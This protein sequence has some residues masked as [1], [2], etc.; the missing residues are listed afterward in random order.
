MTLL[1]KNVQV[2]GARKQLP[3][4]AD[5][6]INGDTIS[7][8]GSFPGK[9]A[10]TVIDG[11]ACYLSSGF[12]DA[13][14]ASDHYLSLF[15]DPGQE[16]FLLQG[17]TTIIGGQ[18]GA[19]LAP[20]LYGNLDSIR[21]W[22]NPDRVNVNWH[23]MREF[24]EHFD[25]QPRGVNFATLAGHGTVR[26]ALIGETSRDL[27]KNELDV[28]EKVMREALKDGACGIST[29]LEYVHTKSTPYREVRLMAEIAAS[30]KGVYASHIRDF[31]EEFRPAL[32]EAIKIAKETNARTF[33]NHF[34]P[35]E[36]ASN[37]Y[38]EALRAIDALPDAADFHFGVY[39]FETRILPLY[40]FLPKWAQQG[41]FETMAKQLTDEWLVPR[42]LKDLGEIHPQDFKVSEASGNESLVGKTLSELMEMYAI[43]DPKEALLALMRTTKLRAIIF[44]KNIDAAL[45]EGALKHKRSLIT[46][47]AGSV[48]KDLR[49]KRMASERSIK[50]F[51]RFLELV[52]SENL[53][54]LRD[55]II[56]IT[57]TPAEKYG[58]AKRG[59]IAEGYFADCVGFKNGEVKF[60]VVN[61]K[62]AVKNGAITGEC[63]GKTLFH[64]T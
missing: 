64:K 2:L 21:K 62:V 40:T 24:L 61:G 29:G 22:A 48:P 37:V 60:V 33:L 43:S 15:E 6:F 39:P 49:G 11:Q 59:E 1:I 23:T 45:L 28:F 20:L 10:D 36:P 57:R 5:I 13:D 9:S 44:H 50:T 32:D 4:R 3:E 63:A 52:E 7:A 16:S 38:E 58:F 42:I 54:P 8:I 53:M 47:S 17:V 19:S 12:I 25:K 27:T 51:T 14:N 18:C 55:A 56:K 34:V 35:T 31:G 30:E 41:N 46:S 26:R